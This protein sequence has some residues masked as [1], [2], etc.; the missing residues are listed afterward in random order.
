M[1][2]KGLIERR[3]YKRFQV[4]DNAFAVH[5]DYVTKLGKI[6]D[7]SISGLSFSYID[8]GK[9]LNGSCDLDIFLSGNGFRLEK[10]QVR[11]ISDVHIVSKIPFSSIIMRRGGVQFEE[12][13]QKQISQVEYFIR[14]LA[15]YAV[16]V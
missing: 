12:L 16:V 4:Q 8:D 5:R 13:L 3:R 6:L 14:N 1:N 7:I 10:V 9:Q 15:I 2:K 11:I